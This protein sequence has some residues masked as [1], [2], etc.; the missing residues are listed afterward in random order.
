M[1]IHY[2]TQYNFNL[3]KPSSSAKWYNKIRLVIV[4]LQLN[5]LRARWPMEQVLYISSFCCVKSLLPTRWDTNPSQVSSQ[6][7]LVLMSPPR[8]DGKLS[9]LKQIRG[10]TNIQISDVP[11]IEL[12]T[13]W[14]E[15]SRDLTNC[16]N[17][18]TQCSFK[19]L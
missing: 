13:L 17:H 10:C 4:H 11:G 16:V 14:S 7:T 3:I 15:G 1:K 12:G 8:K 19:L 5:P 18:L 9:Q 2:C 6:Q